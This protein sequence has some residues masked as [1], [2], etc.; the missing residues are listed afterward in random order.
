MMEGQVERLVAAVE[1]IAVA[2]EGKKASRAP[3]RAARLEALALEV[4]PR[5]ESFLAGW[6]PEEPFTKEDVFRALGELSD[7]EWKAARSVIKGKGWRWDPVG[8][9]PRMGAWVR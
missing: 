3:S 4:A 1:R 8:I 6:C 7:E 2:L 9:G 5:V